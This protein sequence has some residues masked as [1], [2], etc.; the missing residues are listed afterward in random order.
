MKTETILD[1]MEWSDAKRTTA[2]MAGDMS[3]FTKLSRQ[4]HAFR[5]RILDDA[6]RKDTAHRA[7]L[8]QCDDLI[9]ELEQK[10]ARIAELEQKLE[11]INADAK[12]LIG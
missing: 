3:K 7:L 12:W 2:M 6:E 10:D 4:Y 11:D 1:A 9:N 5:A 8:K